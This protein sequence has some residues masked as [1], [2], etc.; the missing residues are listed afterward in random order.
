METVVILPSIF[1]IDFANLGICTRL[2]WEIF[3]W[4]MSIQ[5]SSNPTALECKKIA[6]HPLASKWAYSPNNRNQSAKQAPKKSLEA[7][8]THCG[9]SPVPSALCTM[10]IPPNEQMNNQ[11]KTIRLTCKIRQDNTARLH[12]NRQEKALPLHTAGSEEMTLLFKERAR[13]PVR[14]EMWPLTWSIR[15][16]LRKSRVRAGSWNI[17]Y[18]WELIK[19]KIKSRQINTEN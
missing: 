18:K 4:C 11:I 1:F 7:P 15:L 19:D 14:H 5:F 17:T 16:L 13:R 2:L 8:S 10:Q 12:C 9:I 3:N 6:T